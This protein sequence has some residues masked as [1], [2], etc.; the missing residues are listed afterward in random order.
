MA[1][2]S[3]RDERGPLMQRPISAPTQVGGFQPN[4]TPLPRPQPILSPSPMPPRAP[5]RLMLG[6]Q[7]LAVIP[8]LAQRP[9]P[10]PM[11]Q[12]GATG[13]GTTSPG[14]APGQAGIGMPNPV[15]I[16]RR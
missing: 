8:S 5:Q 3:I 6:Q 9:V 4:P 12:P 15:P 13:P 1:N 16:M 10:A 7:D 11:P 14:V 2:R